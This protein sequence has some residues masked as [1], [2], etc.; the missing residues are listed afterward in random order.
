MRSI[1]AWKYNFCDKQFKLLL[2]EYCINV[3]NF[4][5]IRVSLKK[6]SIDIFFFEKKN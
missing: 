4:L 6:I 2:I 1:I 5:V 3:I